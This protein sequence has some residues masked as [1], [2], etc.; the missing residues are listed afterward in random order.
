MQGG[1]DKAGKNFHPRGRIGGLHEWKM[2]EVEKVSEPNKDDASDE[3]NP[4]QKH[5]KIRLEILREENLGGHYT[6][7]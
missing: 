2:D 6:I 3:V 1:K 4:S 7:L 5:E